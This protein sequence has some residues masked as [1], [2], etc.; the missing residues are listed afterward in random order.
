MAD[1]VPTTGRA[2]R[3]AVVVAIM[4]GMLLS[5]LDQTIVSTAL[6][7]IVGDLG[8]GNHLSWV[9]TSYLLAETIMTVLIGKFGD[10]YGR[11]KMFLLSVVLFLVGSFFAGWADSMTWLVASRAVQGL[12]AGGLMVTA[13]AVIADVVPLSERGK[14]Q[15]AMG[16]VFGVATVVGP[17]LGGLFVDHLSWRW[18]FYVNIPIGVIVLVVAGFALPSVRGAIRPKID[19]LG[20]LLIA[21]A[22]TGLTLVTSWGGTEYPWGSPTIIW[23]AVGSVVALVLFVL[24]ELRAAEP[25]LPMRL[26]RSSVFTV[27]S[28][29]SFIVGFAMLGGVT[30]LPTYLQYVQGASATE[31]GLRMLPLVVGLLAAAIVTGQ[32]ISKTGQYKWFPVAGSLLIAGGL[33]LLSLMDASTTFWVASGYMLVLGLGVGLV[34]PVPTVVVQSTS[35]YSDLG[36]ATSG[37]SFL[38]TLGSSFGVAIFG[39]IY[40]GE[41]PDHLRNAI[42]PGVDP[43]V[44]QT[45][46]GVHALPAAARAPVIQAYVDTLHTMFL[47]AA[48][49]G[50]LAFVVALFLKQVPLRDTARVVAKGNSGVGESFAVPASSDSEVEL[51]K[52]VSLVVSKQDHDPRPEMLARSG[53]PLSFAQAWMLVM[54]FKHSVDDG[55]A[56]LHEI[57][58]QTKVPAGIFEPVARQLVDSGYATEADGHYRFTPKGTEAFARL[59]GAARTWLL[60]KFADW[61][62]TEDHGFAEAVD[63]VAE[64]LIASSRD[65]SAGKHAAHV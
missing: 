57:A 28:V 44:V 62:Q 35:D 13:T 56:T 46:Q 2:A 61:H 5:A 54:V 23:M 18:A 17:L 34:M 37:V 41:L 7:T 39:T 1:E 20:I 64:R 50:L 31:S 38:R 42:P 58:T 3:N 65:L 29:L 8:G 19:Y 59:I 33:V 52:L 27:S 36:V 16:S 40:A 15:G 60:A 43:R 11:K 12:G 48:P 63:R 25:M 22:S 26:F 24:V 51:E 6:P 21:L 10:L 32:V 4:L 47:V 14:Y 55:D 45:V 30:Y 53:V 9:V 49:V